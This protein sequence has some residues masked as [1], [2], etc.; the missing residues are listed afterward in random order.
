MLIDP[1]LSLPPNSLFVLSHP[2]G[3]GLR[4]QTILRTSL[5]KAVP[6][7]NLVSAE[8]NDRVVF[9]SE[10]EAAVHFALHSGPN[11]WLAVRFPFTL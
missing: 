3:W 5:V 1:L 2:N 7:A 8:V 4:E 10:A 6:C 11:R 9:V